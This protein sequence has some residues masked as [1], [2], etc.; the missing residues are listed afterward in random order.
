LGG[1]NEN[2]KL[3]IQLRISVKDLGKVELGIFLN[4]ACLFSQGLRKDLPKDPLDKIGMTTLKGN[5]MLVQKMLKIWN[6]TS[7]SSPMISLQN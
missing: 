7:Q 1:G 5:G 3:W 6:A 4:I 2:E